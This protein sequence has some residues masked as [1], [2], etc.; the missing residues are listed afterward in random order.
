MSTRC[1]R[2]RRPMLTVWIESSQ[3]EEQISYTVTVYSEHSGH[4]LLTS[5]HVMEVRRSTGHIGSLR[6]EESVQLARDHGPGARER[7][8][9]TVSK[10]GKRVALS[11]FEPLILHALTQGFEF[12]RAGDSFCVRAALIACTYWKLTTRAF[13]W[14]TFATRIARDASKI[15]CH[16]V[17]WGVVP[18]HSILHAPT[19]RI[20]GARAEGCSVVFIETALTDVS[21]SGGRATDLAHADATYRRRAAN[22]SLHVAVAVLHPP[23]IAAVKTTLTVYIESPRHGLSMPGLSKRAID[24]CENARETTFDMQSTHLEMIAEHDEGIFRK[25]SMRAIDLSLSTRVILIITALGELN[26]FRISV[27][28]DPSKT[29]TIYFESSRRTASISHIRALQTLTVHFRSPRSAQSIRSLQDSIFRELLARLA[30]FI[31]L[32]IRSVHGHSDARDVEGKMA[33][34]RRWTR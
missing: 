32:A 5:A 34:G 22:P 27:T 31:R 33:V 14:R 2:R 13:D 28:V 25:L 20:N 9:W 26:R 21:E 17:A 11:W 6:R 29:S 23:S 18:A 15:G 7:G 19:Q 24:S 30:T 1:R 8:R 4:K 3:R 10:G 12:W 16:V